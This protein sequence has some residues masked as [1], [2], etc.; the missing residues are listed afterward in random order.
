VFNSLPLRLQVVFCLLQLCDQSV[1]FCNRRVSDLLSAVGYN[2]RLV[3]AWLR[4]ILRVILLALLQTFTIRPSPQTGFLT[5][6]FCL[7]HCLPEGRS[8]ADRARRKM[9]SGQDQR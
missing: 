3:L 7:L 8:G 9:R 1:D 4:I 5:G 6:D 2:L